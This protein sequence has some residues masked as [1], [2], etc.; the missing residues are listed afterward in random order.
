MNILEEI[1]ASKKAD[2]KVTKAIKPLQKIL[3]FIEKNPRPTKSIL[4]SFEQ[5]IHFQLICEIK[6]ASP[7]KGIIQSDFNPIKQ[8]KKYITAG[9]SAISVLTD[10]KYFQ[11]RL[12]DLS[13]IKKISPIP[14]LRK[15]FIFDEYQI[16]E[17]KAAGA[18]FILLIARV[19]DLK[20][21]KQFTQLALNLEM[22]VLF[23]IHDEKELQ[24][25]PNGFPVMIGINNR[26]LHNF[27]VDFNRSIKLIKKIPSDYPV[28]AESGI[29]TAQDCKLLKNEGFRG[30]LIGEALMKS[31][32]PID[33]LEKFYSELNYVH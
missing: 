29:D 12:E 5:N 9:A 26:N 7:S 23:E 22:E 25:I 2:L 15:D 27:S 20:T 19:L 33:L 4:K 1:I 18:D 14:V 28:I 30:A 24:K 11:G 6:K 17:S 21:I 16:F 3:N 32:N 10:F 31:K 8:A 13:N